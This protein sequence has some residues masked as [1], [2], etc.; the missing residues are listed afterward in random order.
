MS[1]FFHVVMLITTKISQIMPCDISHPLNFAFFFWMKWVFSSNFLR[2]NKLTMAKKFLSVE[3]MIHPNKKFGLSKCCAQ[4]IRLKKRREWK[5]K[6]AP[7]KATSWHIA[8]PRTHFTHSSEWMHIRT[9]L[10]L[11]LLLTDSI[12]ESFTGN[13]LIFSVNHC[14]KLFSFFFFYC[15]NKLLFL[16]RAAPL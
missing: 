4:R 15:S 11:S 12:Q 2:T 5:Q 8:V 10:L 9:H 3:L 13:E 14:I 16:P 6:T 7:F 1:V